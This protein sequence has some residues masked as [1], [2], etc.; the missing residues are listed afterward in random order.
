MIVVPERINAGLFVSE[1]CLF[2]PSIQAY[3]DSVSEI[4]L[5]LLL[6]I[7]LSRTKRRST[8]SWPFDHWLVERLFP[9]D[10]FVVGS[11]SLFLYLQNP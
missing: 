10:L 7:A 4:A 9:V 1:K 6:I 2:L 11:P 8:L 3:E 5:M